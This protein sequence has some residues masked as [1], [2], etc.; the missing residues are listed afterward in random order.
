MM[1]LLAVYLTS[2]NES[3]PGGLVGTS[4]LSFVHVGM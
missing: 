3:V 2:P 4:G 1:S